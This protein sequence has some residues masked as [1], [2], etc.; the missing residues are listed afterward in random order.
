MAWQQGWVPLPESSI[1]KA[2]EL[3]AVQVS[4]NT[5]AFQWGRLAVAQPDKVHQAQQSLWKG[6]AINDA[7]RA[8]VDE[9]P[10]QMLKRLYVDL[11]AYQNTAYADRFL[12]KVQNLRAK[13]ESEGKLDLW[14]KLTK[15]YYKLLAFKD[16]FEVARLHSDTNW[17]LSTLAQFKPKAQM[18]FHFAPVWLKSS[19]Q[20]YPQSR[21]KKMAVS[22]GAK[23]LLKLLAKL[24]F[25]RHTAFNP[26]K[27][28]PESINQ[29]EMVQLFETWLELMQNEVLAH[30][31]AFEQ[32]EALLDDFAAVKGYGQVR[33]QS[34][35]LVIKRLRQ[36]T[37]CIAANH[38]NAQGHG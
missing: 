23:P 22:V 33:L 25:L 21:P 36:S 14:V 20:D 19:G 11:Q 26:F 34:F 29:R 3:N 15:T 9:S 12:S 18:V 31:I 4:K 13:F 24:K 7:S 35:L 30:T 8:D 32:I 37:R 27:S 17:Q 5:L 28:S 6:E 38:M 2:I 10:E 1:L 16:E